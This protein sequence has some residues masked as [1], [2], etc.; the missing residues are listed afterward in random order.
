MVFYLEQS[1]KL[2]SA[3]GDFLQ[4]ESDRQLIIE[5]NKTD[6]L[7]EELNNRLLN[8][9]LSKDQRKNI[10]NKILQNDEKLRLKQNEIKKKAFNTQKA[11][12]ISL[13]VVNTV[14]AGISAANATYGGPIAKIAAMTAVIGAG[15]LQVAVIARQKFQPTAASTPVNSSGGGGS[16]SG[17]SGTGD[18]SFNFNLV[19]A[20]QQNQLLNAIQSKFETPL[21]AF[22]VSKD[23]TSQQELDVNIKG[24]AGF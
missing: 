1:K 19:G 17:G 20:S 11:F 2:I 3:V 10:Q 6:S 12:N 22:V 9:N 7:N 4:G 8:E 16:G 15:M 5:Q 18:R 21:K 14:S 23:I 24:T 13:A